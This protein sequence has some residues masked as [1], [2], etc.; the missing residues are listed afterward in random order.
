MTMIEKAEM[1]I[2]YVLSRSPDSISLY[3]MYT[4][5]T[6]V[7]IVQ[8]ASTLPLNVLMRKKAYSARLADLRCPK[9]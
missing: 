3:P 2:V 8:L 7:M 9:T 5:G 4:S 6:R 1:Y